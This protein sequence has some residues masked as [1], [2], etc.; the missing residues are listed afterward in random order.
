MHCT[1]NYSKTVCISYTNN[2]CTCSVCAVL[3][4]IYT[5]SKPTRKI[6]ILIIIQYKATLYNLYIAASCL[7]MATVYIAMLLKLFQQ[8]FEVVC[9]GKVHS[10]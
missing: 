10:K 9:Q 6:M 5:L 8:I 7:D 3:L 4:K 1:Y 2:W